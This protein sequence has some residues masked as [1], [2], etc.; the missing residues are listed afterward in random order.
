L[1]GTLFLAQ[2][3]LKGRI[4]GRKQG[5]RRVFYVRLQQGI[6]IYKDL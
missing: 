5:F 3:G 6:C 2:N 4:L 1:K